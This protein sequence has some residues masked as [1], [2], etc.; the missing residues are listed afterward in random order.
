MN[1]SR[2]RSRKR[3]PPGLR[4][5]AASGDG[6]WEINLV[7]GS[8]WFSDWFHQ[9]LG[10]AADSRR[11]TVNDLKN[12]LEPAQWDAFMRRFRAHLEQAVPFD[13]RLR[14]SCADGR[15]EWWQFRGRAER[16]DGGLPVSVA[17]SAR[18][19]A[20]AAGMPACSCG[21]FEVL[22]VA[23]A[24]LDAQGSIVQANA[25]W[26]ELAPTFESSH[27]AQIM[28]APEGSDALELTLGAGGETGNPR[29]AKGVAKGAGRRVL[30]ARARRCQGV[31]DWV[32]VLE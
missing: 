3:P 8:A 19:I 18:V 12:A 21:V 10:W 14:V 20:A 5:L 1:D 4:A 15:A 16:T 30:K 17:G 29:E 7:D 32:V 2:S 11:S 6:F 9:K 31:A 23:T 26:R 22:P 27:A 28:S 24:M 25:R 13:A